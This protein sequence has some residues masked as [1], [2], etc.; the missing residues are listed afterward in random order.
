MSAPSS[1][2]SVGPAP[3]PDVCRIWTTTGAVP[4]V[5]SAATQ[6]EGSSGAVLSLPVDLCI[7]PNSFP[8]CLLVCLSHRSSVLAVVLAV[9]RMP[10]RRPIRHSH[11]RTNRPTHRRKPRLL[12]TPLQRSQLVPVE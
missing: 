12:Q 3:V 10:L 6:S 8:T 4:I 5:L 11:R 9:S 2:L 1:L 7:C